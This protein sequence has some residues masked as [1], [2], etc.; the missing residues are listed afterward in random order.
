MWSY[1][2]IST[3]FYME[4]GVSI[5]FIISE[6]EEEDRVFELRTKEA[7][8]IQQ[9][10]HVELRTR[11]EKDSNKE[12]PSSA[13][14]PRDLK[15]EFEDQFNDVVSRLQSKQLFQSDWD[16]A[17]FAVFFIFIGMI[18]LLVILVLIRCCC[19]CCCDDE[20]PRR[21]KVGIENMALEP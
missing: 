3:R 8:R 18:L 7:G 13:M 21:R 20:K 12:T 14:E 11:K 19:C 2:T 9:V 15:Q 16:I 10:R 1:C 4:C 5:S 6:E 17:S